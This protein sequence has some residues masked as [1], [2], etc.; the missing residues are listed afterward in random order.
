[1]TNPSSATPITPKKGR[2]RESSSSNPGP[3]KTK[4]K[5]PKTS[6]SN[7]L[8]NDNDNDTDQHSYSWTPEK[9]EVIVDYLI[10]RAISGLDYDELASKVGLSKAQL[11]NALAKGQKSNLRD[12]LVTA[13]KAI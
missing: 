10:G 13:A 6:P 5:K 2:P 1:M 12:R 3:I 4:P 8:D 11:K 9:R 7:I